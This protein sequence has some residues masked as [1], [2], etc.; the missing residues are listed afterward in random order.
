MRIGYQSR[1]PA[2]FTLIE[3]M[4]VLIIVGVMLSAAI[5][6]IRPLSQDEIRIIEAEKLRAIALSVADESILRRKPMGIR[7]ASH[8]YRVVVSENG[9]WDTKDE[10]RFYRYRALAPSLRLEIVEPPIR[11]LDDEKAIKTAKPHMYFLPN[12]EISPFKLAFI[13]DDGGTSW[14][15]TDEYNDVRIEQQ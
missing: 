5:L 2:G 7:L 13:S 6:Y 3:L 14:V 15:Y 11:L 1:K 10:D 12:S 9:A 4:V 8:G